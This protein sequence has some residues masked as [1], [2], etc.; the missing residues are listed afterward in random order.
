[1]TRTYVVVDHDEDENGADGITSTGFRSRLDSHVLAPSP[2]RTRRK[3]DE[4]GGLTF[5]CPIARTALAHGVVEEREQ[6]R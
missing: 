2:S 3:N 1:M 6:D 4:P 5:Q